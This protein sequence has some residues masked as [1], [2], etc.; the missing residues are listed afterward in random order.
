MIRLPNSSLKPEEK[1]NVAINMTDVCV[2]ICANAV[3]QK[4]PEIKEKE[5]IKR[6]RERIIFERRRQHEV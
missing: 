3:K 6:V 2:H 5:L 4:Y 1:V